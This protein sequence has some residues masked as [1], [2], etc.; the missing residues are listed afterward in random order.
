MMESARDA[1]RR[2]LFLA[3]TARDAATTAA[4]LSPL[5]IPLAV[6]T[7]FDE[8]LREIRV[9][10]G[11]LLLTE[12]AVAAPHD[13]ALRAVLSTQ[14]PWSDLPVLVLTRTGADSAESGEAARTLG[15]VTLL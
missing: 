12:E 1:D 6:C 11:A 15:N 14:P 2:L 4:V 13:S 3:T 8:V 5:R 10:A 9:G 7:T